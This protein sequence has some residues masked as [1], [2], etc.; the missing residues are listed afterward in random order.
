MYQRQGTAA[1]K[2]NLDNTWALMDTIEHPYTQFKSIHVAGTN[3]KGSTSHMLAS[4]LQ[5]S[6]YKIGLYTSPHLLDFR[7]RIRINGA[8]ISEEKVIDFVSE[9]RTKFE[10]I[11]LSFFEWTVGLAFNYFALEKV[12]VAIIEVG[13]GGRLDSTNV[14]N[15]LLSI[16][17]NIGLDH[18]QFLGDTL[19]EIAGEKAGI[20]KANT[21]VVIGEINPI[22]ESVFRNKAHELN[23]PIFFAEK[24]VNSSPYP[25]DLLG[26]YQAK[27]QNTV[28]A[29]LTV[30]KQSGLKINEKSISKG[31]NSVIQNTGLN[32]RW[33]ILNENP[34]TICD[35]AHNEDGLRLIMSQL[36]QYDEK[37][38][39]FVLGFVNDKEVSNL[40]TLFPKDSNYY[41]CQANIPRALP[42]QELG[43]TAIDTGIVGAS[44]KTVDKAVSEAQKNAKNSDIIYIGG[45]TFVVAEALSYW[46]KEKL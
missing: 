39:H 10:S 24:I 5:E 36:N 31:F 26:A 6:G 27:N 28:L 1:Y 4:I 46:S 18:T 16:I 40:L 35:T 15:P 44:F 11:N 14:I 34:L 9:Y 21:P 41:F 3:G 32:G 19:A 33:Q 42:V 12:D 20:I 2:A 30:L 23:A 7:E 8:M 43:N 22:T 38:I 29:S 37:S 25:C 45:S 17:T 13:M